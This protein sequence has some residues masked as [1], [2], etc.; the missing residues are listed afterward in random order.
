LFFSAGDTMTQAMQELV[1]IRPFPFAHEGIR[2]E[3]FKP[4]PQQKPVPMTARCAEVA[5]K[6]GWARR[7][8]PPQG[9]VVPLP[10]APPADTAD[11]A[12]N[13][14]DE[15]RG[16]PN[17]ESEPVPFEQQPGEPQNQTDPGRPSGESG[18]EQQSSASHQG[19]R[20]RRNR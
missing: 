8:L 9:P 19:R 12:G 17:S 2:V 6:E 13:S 18:Q 20:S 15:K 3:H 4:D 1:V 16:G 7:P 10:A 11:A 14:T 5:L